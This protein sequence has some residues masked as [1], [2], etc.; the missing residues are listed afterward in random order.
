MRSVLFF[1]EMLVLVPIALR[2]PFAGVLIFCFI[3]FGNLHRLTWGFAG[4]IPWAYITVI[5]TLIGCIVAQ[6]PKQLVVNPTMALIGVFI[7][8][9]TVT[10][11]TALAPADLVWSKWEQVAKVFFFLLVTAALTNERHRIHALIWL[12]VIS[13]GYYGVKGGGFTL[14]TGG[15][16]R[17][18]GPPSS[19]VA[20]NNHLAAGLLVTLPL[21]NYLRLQS[22]HRLVRIGLLLGMILTLFSILGSYSRGALIGLAAV[23]VVLWLRMPNKLVTALVAAA[24]VAVALS[25]MPQAWMDRMW[26]LQEADQTLSG[27]SRLAMWQA[28]W[29]MAVA[30]PLVGTGFMGPYTE[31]VISAYAPGTLPR[32]VHSIWFETLGEHGFP[33]FFVWLAMTL[34]GV[35][36]TIR[37]VRDSRAVPELGWCRDLARMAQVSMVAYVVAGTF[38]VPLLLGFLLHPPGGDRGHPGAGRADGARRGQGRC[39][40]CRA[41]D[42]TV[43]SRLAWD[44]LAV[45]TSAGARRLWSGRRAVV[46]RSGGGGHAPWIASGSSPAAAASSGW[47]SGRCGISRSRPGCSGPSTHAG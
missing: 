31:Y 21:I 22:A 9:I 41:H 37:I 30:R 18:L 43:C 33:T 29:N 24:L 13:L 39:L 6:E 27:Q 8:C 3:S 36:N 5:A 14:L 46:A 34:V 7:V 44:A 12:M 17:V 11:V 20:D 35:W 25:V 45:G 2:R 16:G 10:S 32:A 26:T 42:E 1:C 15:G 38:P 28:A 23:S 47:C 4:N 40:A 19:M